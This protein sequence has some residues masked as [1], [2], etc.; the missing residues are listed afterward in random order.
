MM[1]GQQFRL[2]AIA[3]VC[4]FWSEVLASNSE[5]S[6]VVV[7]CCGGCTVLAQKFWAN[8]PLCFVRGGGGSFVNAAHSRSP[9][10]HA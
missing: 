5:Y 9:N 8:P 1:L 6:Y 10:G 3:S 4:T 7:V 2:S